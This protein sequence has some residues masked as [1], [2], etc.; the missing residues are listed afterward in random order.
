MA[1]HLYVRDRDFKRHYM[2]PIQEPRPVDKYLEATR[3]DFSRIIFSPCFRRLQGKTQ[4]FPTSENHPFYRNRLTHSIEVSNIA[5][6]IAAYLNN[7]SSD[8]QSLDWKINYDIVALAG[9]A[10][11]LG[12]PPFGHTGEL[13]L[14][15]EMDK[16]RFGRFEGNAQ[17]LRILTNLEQRISLFHDVNS[18]YSSNDLNENNTGL[19][20]TYRSLA[21]ILKYD[22]R[23]GDTSGA[24]FPGV[25][26]LKGYYPED[27]DIV[28]EI[29]SHVLRKPYRAGQ[30]PRLNTIEC[31]ILDIADDIAYSSFDLEDCLC[32]DFIH[33]MDFLSRLGSD[34]MEQIAETVSHGMAKRGIDETIE[35]EDVHGC[36]FDI[37]KDLFEKSLDFNVNSNFERGIIA[38]F[39]YDN[40]VELQESNP[41]RRDFSMRRIQMLLDSL[42]IIVNEDEPSLSK[43]TIDTSSLF[44][45]ECLKAMNY[46]MV[47]SSPQLKAAEYR[48]KR[49]VSELF[50]IILSD[51]RLLPEDFRRRMKADPGYLEG[52][53]SRERVEGRT[54]CDFISGMT[55]AYASRFY[56]QLTGQDYSSILALRPYT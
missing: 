26:E 49:I 21:S 35:A 7:K 2:A 22:K 41:I 15:N 42:D 44:E 27:A 29:K 12:H 3:R 32:A 45:I 36:L 30:S 33:P 11:D 39:A 51:E 25:G 10:H 56:S 4:L 53:E 28:D 48:G 55:D 52:G 13:A 43:L 18:M 23:V 54:V 19:N 37:F 38:A 6:M 24:S 17:T 31:Q 16:R 5:A 46:E 20:L 40:G 14:D 34:K 50:E 9:L 47:I 1:T 8:M